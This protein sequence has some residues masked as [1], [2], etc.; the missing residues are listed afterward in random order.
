M[1]DC[2]TWDWN[3]QKDTR[4]SRAASA[5]EGLASKCGGATSSSITP[6]DNTIGVEWDGGRVVTVDEGSAKA[7]CCWA[8]PKYTCRES[9][10]EVVVPLPISRGVLP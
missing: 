6:F 4:D 2:F 10:G 1:N 7:S 9:A 3:P 5:G 8:S